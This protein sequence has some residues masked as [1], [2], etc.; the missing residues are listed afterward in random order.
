MPTASIGAEAEFR[1]RCIRL[2]DAKFYPKRAYGGRWAR[3]GGSTSS[4]KVAA[5]YGISVVLQRG[6]GE[7]LLIWE[8]FFCRANDDWCIPEDVNFPVDRFVFCFEESDKSDKIV[9]TIL[10]RAE[11]L[12]WL[13]GRPVEGGSRRFCMGDVPRSCVVVE[14]ELA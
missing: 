8:Q 4:Q 12:V 7:T 2:L 9:V 1:S 10:S 6:A 14:E 3:L 11:F 13:G 5:H